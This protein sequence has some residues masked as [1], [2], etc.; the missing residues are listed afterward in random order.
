[1]FLLE[2]KNL[3]VSILPYLPFLSAAVVTKEQLNLSSLVSRLLESAIVA[4]VILYANV[5]VMDTKVKHIEGSITDIRLNDARIEGHI[6]ANRT[7]LNAILIQL[8]GLRKDIQH[9][10]DKSKN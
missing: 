9:Q 3:V 7:K 6:E 8:E 4:A 5:Q 10:A 1:M 2:I